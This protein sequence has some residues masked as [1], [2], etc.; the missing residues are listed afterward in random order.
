MR[1]KCCNQY[2]YDRANTT[3]THARLFNDAQGSPP[4]CRLHSTHQRERVG[5]KLRPAEI[6]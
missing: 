5:E 2:K 6:A 4:L 1:L 3:T